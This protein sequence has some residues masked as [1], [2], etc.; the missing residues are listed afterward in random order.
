MHTTPLGM[1][2]TATQSLSRNQWGH[3]MFL[4][5]CLRTRMSDASSCLATYTKYTDNYAGRILTNQF[6]QGVQKPLVNLNR[7]I[8]NKRANWVAGSRD[9][10]RFVA[11]RGMTEKLE[12]V[13]RFNN[14]KS[15]IRRTAKVSFSRRCVLVHHRQE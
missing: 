13:W 3:R 6:D 12:E 7:Q 1:W 5:H 4:A 10:F 9:S 14:K 15:L 11:R 2:S 8:I